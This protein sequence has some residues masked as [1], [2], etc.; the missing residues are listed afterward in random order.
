MIVSKDF[1]KLARPQ[2]YTNQL[3]DPY[4][5]SYLEISKGCLYKTK[6]KDCNNSSVD[7]QFYSAIHYQ[8]LNLD[9]FTYLKG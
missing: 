9:F 1:I 7:C 3:T 2:I 6:I 4:R 8:M 5:E